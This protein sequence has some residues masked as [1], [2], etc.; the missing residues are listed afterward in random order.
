MRRNS[1]R[2]IPKVLQPRFHKITAKPDSLFHYERQ[3]L[4]LRA[5]RDWR[6]IK[7]DSQKLRDHMR[8]EI[9]G[10]QIDVT[11]HSKEYWENN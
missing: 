10:Q 4:T 8:N 9:I 2:S 7:G 5:R 3:I 1:G 11:K 6:H